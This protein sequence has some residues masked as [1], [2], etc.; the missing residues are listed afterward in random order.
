MSA[1]QEFIASDRQ[2]PS[3]PPHRSWTHYVAL[4]LALVGMVFL[5]AACGDGGKKKGYRAANSYEGC[6]DQCGD[7]SECSGGLG[8]CQF[9]CAWLMLDGLGPYA[10]RLSKAEKE[11][12][13]GWGEYF[14]CINANCTVDEH[15]DPMYD[16]E[17]IDECEP[18]QDKYA[19]ACDAADAE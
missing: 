15:G 14:A 5:G 11:C 7:A 16:E 2:E 18:I 3:M 17:A 4:L 13:R 12:F 6:M 9:S 10:P 1:V 19:A 8:D